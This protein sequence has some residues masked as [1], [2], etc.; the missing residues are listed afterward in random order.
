MIDTKID[1]GWFKVFDQLVL[2]KKKICVQ[3]AYKEGKKVGTVSNEVS[4][5]LGDMMV[6]LNEDG[7]KFGL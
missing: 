5:I 3:P 4:F 6:F 1:E 2:D 7:I